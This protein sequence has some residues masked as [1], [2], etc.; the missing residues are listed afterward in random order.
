MPDPIQFFI[1]KFEKLCEEEEILGR[2]PI[3]RPYRN[4]AVQFRKCKFS[5]FSKRREIVEAVGLNA[6]FFPAR[7]IPGC[8]LLSDSGTTTMTIEQWSKLLLGDEAYGAN[9]G[10][11][12]LKQQIIDT[13]GEEWRTYNSRR[14]NMFIFHQGR[15][16]EYALFSNLAKE[17]ITQGYELGRVIIPSN[18]HFDTTQANIEAQQMQAVNLPC[19][20]HLN[21]D[22]T[23]RFRGNINLE[24][25]EKL[26]KENAKHVP[27]VYMT[28]TNNTAGGQPV[29][30][31]NIKKAYEMCH[32]YNIPLFLDASRFAENS[33]FIKENEDEY[34]HLTIPEIVKETF[35]YCDGFHAS[36]KKDGLVNIGGILV[37]KETGLFYKKYPE[38]WQKLI[39]HQILIEGNP[40][41]GGLA[42]RDLK[43]LVEGLRVVV[44]EDYL[45]FRIH[46]TRRFGTKLV[47]YNIPIVLPVGGHAIYIDV[48]KFFKE[49]T[50]DEDFKGISIVALILIAGHRLCELGVF[51]F[52]KYR[53]GVEIPPDPRVN[54]IRAAV[55]R[56]VYE[57]QDLF[58]VAEAIKILYEYQDYIPAVNIIYGRNLSLRHFKARF[59]FRI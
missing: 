41:Y 43:A 58:S 17:L 44:T 40:S 25:L 30:L 54:Y 13:F 33:W 52:G 53:N 27:L 57:D 26:L 56:L 18:A 3:P 36:F 47:E 39:D 50:Q 31:A 4:S 45:K 46:Q 21:D 14:E 16:C 28:I 38:F 59:Q 19:V 23:F 29:S 20:E 7:E 42:G 55:P 11:F 8:D 51:A 34:K 24:A 32:S 37:I 6:F 49:K 10:Y 48:D 2:Y 5:E 12:E 9:E 22:K 35:K 1:S 15:A